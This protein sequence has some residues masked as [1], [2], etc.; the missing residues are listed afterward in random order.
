MA[1]KKQKKGDTGSVAYYAQAES[2]FKNYGPVRGIQVKSKT[3][4]ALLCYYRTITN[5][6]LLLRHVI[7][8]PQQFISD[9]YFV[10]IYHAL[11][12]FIVM[13]SIMRNVLQDK[14]VS[15]LFSLSKVRTKPCGLLP[16]NHKALCPEHLQPYGYKPLA[17]ETP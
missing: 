5:S 14:L 6:R 3:Q 11:N 8:I 12:Q 7:Y 9:W 13:Y 17:L 4:R 10:F 2:K 16:R 1:K 15:V